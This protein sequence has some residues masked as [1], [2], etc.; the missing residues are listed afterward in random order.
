MNEKQEEHIDTHTEAHKHKS[1]Q[2]LD[3]NLATSALQLALNKCGA[4]TSERIMKTKNIL[5][6]QE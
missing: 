6:K 5:E 3:A 2:L 1:H 4:V